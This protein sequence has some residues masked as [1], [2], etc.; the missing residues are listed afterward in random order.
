MISK[1]Y[2]FTAASSVTFQEQI[3]EIKIDKPFSDSRDGSWIKMQPGS[4]QIRNGAS[5]VLVECLT[6]EEEDAG[7]L[8]GGFYMSPSEVMTLDF[9]MGCYMIKVKTVTGSSD[10]RVNALYYLKTNERQ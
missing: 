6:S 8:Q 5:P 3:L 2:T 7:L 4:V 9:N 10:I 1:T